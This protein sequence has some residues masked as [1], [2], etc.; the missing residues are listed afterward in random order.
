[1]IL[2]ERK[3]PLKLQALESLLRRIPVNHRQREAIENDLIKR[4]AGYK[5]EK[6]LDYYLSFYD[7]DGIYI[8]ND[9]VLQGIRSPFQ[10]DSLVISLKFVLLI[11]TKYF[12]GTLTFD[13]TFKQMIRS[14]ENYEEAF[15]NPVLQAQRQFVQFKEWLEEKNILYPPLEYIVVMSNPQTILKAEEDELSKKIIRVDYLYNYLEKLN[16]KYTRETYTQEMAKHLVSVL[17]SEQ[18]REWLS[19]LSQYQ[20]DMSEIIRGVQCVSC[21]FTPMQR[22]LKKWFCPKCNSFSRTAHQQAIKD[23]F[24]LIKPTITNSE[25]RDFLKLDS[26]YV[27]NGILTS[28]NFPSNGVTRGKK[29]YMP[30]WY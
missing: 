27:A 2:K 12:S 14:Y 19:V 20:I 4:K 15:F 17:L 9:I 8:L 23:Y 1:M 11:E 21:N 16:Q 6:N 18:K 26:R 3:I 10:I 28:M 24:L 22:K 29:Y 25:C 5:G 13:Q 30:D 7:H